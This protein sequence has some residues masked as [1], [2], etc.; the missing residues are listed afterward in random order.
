MTFIL[1]Y[2]QKTMSVNKAN[3]SKLLK[4][5]ALRNYLMECHSSSVDV[6]VMICVQ[7]I[8]SRFGQTNPLK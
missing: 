8:I 6:F 3:L 4:S 7:L 5:Q 1:I 2:L